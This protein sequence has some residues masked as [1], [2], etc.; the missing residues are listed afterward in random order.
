MVNEPS[1]KGAIN[2]DFVQKPHEPHAAFL[3]CAKPHAAPCGFCFPI[4]DAF[5]P[6]IDAIEYFWKLPV[7][8]RHQAGGASVGNGLFLAASRP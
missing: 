7:L 2:R 4:N 1:P 3:H 8:I 5:D 6:C